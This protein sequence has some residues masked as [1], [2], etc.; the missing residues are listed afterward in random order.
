MK[1]AIISDIHGNLEAFQAALNEIEKA[2]IK[3]IFSAGDIV[4][5]GPD[6]EECIKI[7]RSR[8]ISSVMGNHDY[9]VNEVSEEE[10]FNAYARLAIRWTREKLSEEDKTFL[11][12][13]PFSLVKDEFTIFH[14]TLDPEE[15]FNYILMSDDAELSFKNMKT[16]VGFFGHSHSAGCFIKDSNGIISYRSGII[17]CTIELD[18]ENKYLINVGSVGQP[19][20]GNPNGAFAIFD[21]DEKTVSIKR[22]AYDIDKTAKKIIDSGLPRFLA[23]R[24]YE[25]V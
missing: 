8:G 22:F 18:P 16:W 2:G 13:L 15:P 9:A 25:G 24:L 3:Y 20:D 5:Y 1:Y 19:R 12:S 23:E 17:D 21:T 14:G 4:G 11:K 6:P 7:I 10:L